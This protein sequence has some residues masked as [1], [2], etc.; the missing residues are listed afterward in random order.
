M[1]AA[2]AGN[3]DAVQALLAR[4]ADVDA[5]D[6]RLGETALMWAAADNHRRGGRGC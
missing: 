3:P 4:G 2:R 1:T 5:K 6:D